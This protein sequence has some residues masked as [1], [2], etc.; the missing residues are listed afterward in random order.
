MHSQ[1]FGFTGNSINR[2]ATEEREDINSVSANTLLS[3]RDLS[4]NLIG[5]S[6]AGLTLQPAVCTINTQADIALQR[7]VIIKAFGSLQGDGI[8][9]EAYRWT[10]DKRCGAHYE[11]NA[12]RFYSNTL[13]FPG[14]SFDSSVVIGRVSWNVGIIWKPFN[15][16]KI[17]CFGNVLW[18]LRWFRSND[19][20]HNF[21]F[22][23][24]GGKTT[25]VLVHNL[26]NDDD[27][28][29]QLSIGF[30]PLVIFPKRTGTSS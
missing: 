21:F 24:G 28:C 19:S 27:W 7:T 18:L 17:W 4:C 6:P 3:G 12:V 2:V 9:V 20:N 30:S 29:R 16:H 25:T 10:Y 5:H 8:L 13:D 1:Y 15:Q 14:V 11:L 23:G 26:P 22:S